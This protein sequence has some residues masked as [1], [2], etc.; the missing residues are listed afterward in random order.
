MVAKTT[1]SE[2]TGRAGDLWAWSQEA[3]GRRL[4]QELGPMSADRLK[5]EIALHR[6]G[7][8]KQLGPLIRR[9]LADVHGRVVSPEI[10]DEAIQRAVDMR[11]DSLLEEVLN[12]TDEI[13]E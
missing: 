8:D 13:E 12:E 3:I 11:L 5:W 9:I 7:R 4:L 2:K 1:P 10:R 6:H